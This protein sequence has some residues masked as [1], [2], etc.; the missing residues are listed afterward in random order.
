MDYFK[1]LFTR[2]PTKK[3]EDIKQN[4]DI[5]IEDNKELLKIKNN[6]NIILNDLILVLKKDDTNNLKK[7]IT[8][9]DP[10]NCNKFTVFLSKNIEHNFHK[11]Q[12]DDLN[13]KLYVSKRG[14]AECKTPKCTE[15]DKDERLDQDKKYTKRDLCMRISYHFVRQLNIVATIITVINPK[16]NFCFDRIKRI[17]DV[18]DSSK[19]AKSQKKTGSNFGVVKICHKDD[20]YEG[21]VLKQTGFRELL[22]LYY[23]HMISNRPE[24]TANIQEEYAKLSALFENILIDTDKR[25]EQ[26]MDEYVLSQK[27][28]SFKAFNFLL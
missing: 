22:N 10:K 26:I 5:N 6:F 7:L 4:I 2:T 20:I 17:L 3:I 23:F 16:T 18:I 13:S 11:F 27:Q 25:Q 12:V 14:F 19:V 8:L 1:K 9:T 15:L 21:D 28:N 24:D